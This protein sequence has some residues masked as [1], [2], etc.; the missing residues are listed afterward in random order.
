MGF[1][2]ELDKYLTTEPDNGFNE[3]CEAVIDGIPVPIFELYEDFL[4]SD[5]NIINKWFNYLHIK[6]YKIEDA[7]FLIGKAAIVR[8]EVI[9]KPLL[10]LYTSV[11]N[12][13]STIKDFS[14]VREIVFVNFCE[15]GICKTAN[16]LWNKLIYRETWVKTYR[17]WKHPSD[18][19]L[20]YWALPPHVAK[21]T[22]DLINSIKARKEIL[23]KII[24]VNSSYG[25]Y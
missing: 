8:A 5:N 18:D 20:S 21:N 11:Y 9:Q 15:G 23:E 14:Q 7:S 12:N 3:W 1:K 17:S 2:E 24:E 19:E 13:I 6:Q 16:D 4:N 25:A 10:E 22:E